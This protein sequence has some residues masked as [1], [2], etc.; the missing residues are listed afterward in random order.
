[1]GLF[2]SNFF[3]VFPNFPVPH[4]PREISR[5]TISR[6]PISRREMCISNCFAVPIERINVLD[7]F[8][9]SNLTW[10]VLREI[11]LWDSWSVKYSILTH[12]EALYL[13]FCT[14]LR[15]KLTKWTKFTESLQNPQNWFYIKSEWYKNLE[16]STL[17]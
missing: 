9:F 10:K 3:P 13:N 1:M 11:N 12:L 5:S 17:W 15:L 4:F 16:I 7:L 8:W 6:F 2:W 14:F